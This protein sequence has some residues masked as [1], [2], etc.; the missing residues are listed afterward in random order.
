MLV[1]I[2]KE[3]YLPRGQN[4]KHQR[5]ASYFVK[6]VDTG[7]IILCIIEGRVGKK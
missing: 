4:W 2:L 7:M 3:N 6:I 5:I 1:N